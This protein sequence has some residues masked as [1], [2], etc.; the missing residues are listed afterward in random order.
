MTGVWWGRLTPRSQRGGRVNWPQ[1]RGEAQGV[2][3]GVGLMRGRGRPRSWRRLPRLQKL[4]RQLVLKRLGRV[5]RVVRVG[6]LVQGVGLH[7]LLLLVWLHRLWGGGG[8]LG[9]R[10]VFGR[11]QPRRLPC[12]SLRRRMGR[13]ERGG[14]T[15][16]A[17]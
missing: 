5:G 13:P 1:G 15:P 16:R 9:H 12:S 4:L 10:R 14:W 2:R 6:H 17:L 11:W 8:Y 3:K 7:R